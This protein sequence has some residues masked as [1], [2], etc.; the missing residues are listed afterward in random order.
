MITT[1]NPERSRNTRK[2]LLLAVLFTAIAMPAS[3][4][5][6]TFAVLQIGTR[7]YTNVTVTTKAKTYIFFLHSAGMTSVKI[8]DLPSDLQQTLGY[9]AGGKTNPK[10]VSARSLTADPAQKT[11]AK[12]DL[13]SIGTWLKERLKPLLAS[14]QMQ[15][16]REAL[17]KQFQMSKNGGKPNFGAINPKIFYAVLGIGFLL[18]VFSSYCLKLI[19]L[20]AGTEP[21]ALIWVPLF[22]LIPMLR[23]AKM[24]PAWFV[25]YFIPVLNLVVLIVWCFKIAQARQK[26]A[27][28]GLLLLLPGLGLLAFLYLAFSDGKSDQQEKKK[29]GPQ[30]M[31]LRTA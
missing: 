28:V 25:G 20:K 5:E 26:S 17:E 29:L 8:E 7:M 15:Q 30:R 13:N 21:G 2:W 11:P 22:Q 10:E 14:T 3:A 18:F 12:F 31:A 9:S 1:G 27:L 6:Q 24:S 19:C 16:A 4:G 23:A